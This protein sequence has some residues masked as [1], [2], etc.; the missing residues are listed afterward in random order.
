MTPA[1]G[2]GLYP[3]L[4]IIIHTIRTLAAVTAPGVFSW[5]A[6]KNCKKLEKKFADSKIIVNFATENKTTTQTQTLK[7]SHYERHWKSNLRKTDPHGSS[8]GFGRYARKDGGCGFDAD[9]LADPGTKRQ[10]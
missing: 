5:E 10:G 8:N 3:E 1:A 4:D 2:G 7:S 9:Q 6:K